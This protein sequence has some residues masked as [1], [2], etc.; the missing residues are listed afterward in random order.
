VLWAPWEIQ[1]ARNLKPLQSR[2]DPADGGLA[3]R[4]QSITMKQ[5]VHAP[6]EPLKLVP[7]K[8]AWI[9]HD[10][11]DLHAIYRRP[12]FKEDEFGEQ[13][14]EYADGVPTWDITAPLPIKAH[15]KWTSKGFEY[16]TLADMDS[17]VTA[18][19]FGT[20]EGDWKI[21]NQ[22]QT[23][24]PWNYKRYLAGQ[25]ITA[26]RESDELVADVN[27]FGSDVVE[28]LR[29]RQDPD[30]ALPEKLRG[31]PAGG[32]KNASEEVAAAVDLAPAKKV[33]A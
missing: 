14:R 27:E 15:N 10:K 24:G 17:L 32:V 30:F 6:V 20:I 31:I 5:P 3:V 8:S 1:A 13:Y 18:A 28:R 33:K 2:S 9:A 11:I 16:V 22:H 7:F 19:R 29:R 12:R 23:G 25:T 21:Y 4:T 26:S